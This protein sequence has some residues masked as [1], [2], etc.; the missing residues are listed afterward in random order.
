MKL[1]EVVLFP[2]AGGTEE[3]EGRLVD[4]QK[5]LS[6]WPAAKA[7][8]RPVPPVH[9]RAV[10]CHHIVLER[11][12]RSRQPRVARAQWRRG[13]AFEVRVPRGAPETRALKELRAKVCK[14]SAAYLLFRKQGVLTNRR[15]TEKYQMAKNKQVLLG[16]ELA[17][18][19]SE[20]F[21]GE[22]QGDSEY[23]ETGPDAAAPVQEPS[24]QQ[25][26]AIQKVHQNLGHPDAATLARTLRIGG[27]PDYVWQW[28]KKHFRCPA[29]ASGARPKAPRPAAVPRSY[30]PNTV[31][32]V[33]LFHLSSWDNSQQ[34][35]YLNMVDLGTNFQ[36][37]ERVPSKEPLAVWK[38]M[39]RTW[40][41]FLGFPQ[42]ILCD[43]GTEFLGAFRD[44]C[45]ELGVLIHTIGARAPYQNGRCERHGGLFKMMIERAKWIN[46]PASVE[47]WRLLIRETEAAKNRLSDRSGFSPAQRMLGQT[48]RV[49]S[50]LH[51]DSWL[52][53]VLS[54]NDEE[55]MKVLKARA[56]AQRA[57]AETN[58][59]TILRRSLRARPRTQVQFSPGDV[60][61]VWRQNAWQ[62]PGV[63]VLPEGANSYVNMKGK[64][65]KVSNEHVRSAV[66]EE[67]K[68]T[69]AVHEVFRDLR[70]R[71]ARDGREAPVVQDLT[72]EPRPPASERPWYD[73]VVAEGDARGLPR[74][75][76]EPDLPE[77]PVPLPEP[78]QVLPEVPLTPEPPE[79]P[80]PQVPLGPD[81]EEG[82][83]DTPERQ[84]TE[85]PE[86][87]QHN[88]ERPTREDLL[89]SA[90][91]SA[92]RAS[93]VDGL[94]RAAPTPT[95]GGV[96]TA[97][98]Q[99]SYRPVRPA[100]E[101]RREEAPHPYQRPAEDEVFV[102]EPDL[103]A[104][105]PRKEGLP[106]RDRWQLL[107]QQG[108]LRRH[109]T[110]WRT[111]LFSPWEGSKMP[112]DIAA[113]NSERCTVQVFKNGEKKDLFDDWRALR[114]GVSTKA[115]SKWKGYTDFYLTKVEAKKLLKNF[116]G[117][118]GN[119]TQDTYAFE[120]LPSEVFAAKK[121][122][123]DEVNERDIPEEEWP[124][125]RQ[126]DAEEWAKIEASGAVRV[127]SPQESARVLQE[128]AAKGQASRVI[129]SRFVRRRKPSE[130]IGEPASLKSRWCVRGD[131]DPDAAELNAY[132][133]TVT[134]QNLQV[135]LQLVASL[136][137]PGACG[138]LKAAFTQSD[139]LTRQAGKLYV[140]Q[141]RGGLPGMEPGQIMEVVVGV[142]G[143]VDG[144]L[145]W[146]K[147]LKSYLTSELGFKQSRIDPTVFMLYVDHQLN[148]LLVVEIDDILSFGFKEHEQRMAQLQSRFK[149]GKYKKLQELA[150]G[151][152]FNGRRLQQD[153]D[154]SI[155]VDMS[156]FIE[157]RLKP[158]AILRE[159]KSDPEAKATEKEISSARGAVGSLAWLSKEGRPDLAGA[160]SMLAA[161]ISTLQVK[162]LM[163]INKCIAGAKARRDLQLKF[164]PI[165]V[166]D[167]CWG[168]VTDASW[169]NHK[170]GSSQGATAVIAFH[171]D[172]LRGERA[173]CTMIWWKSGKLRRKVGSTLAAEAQALLRGLGDL[174]W[175]KAV[176]HEI[177]DEDFT[178]EAFKQD[179]KSKAELVLQSAEADETLKNSLAV[180]DAKSLYDNMMKDGSQSQDKFTALDVAIARERVDGLGVE[181]RWVEHQAMIVDSLTKL[182][183]NKDSMLK[184]LEDGTFRLEA[185][186][187]QLEDRERRRLE[188]TVKRR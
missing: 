51:S 72:T 12:H 87:E 70:D 3:V 58:C 34:E 86:V 143:L 185:E 82:R 90:V 127:L 114:P 94:P 134:T 76:T 170:D 77:P 18:Q 152:M 126:A 5:E 106:Q 129:D 59:S 80:V 55:L 132:A 188:G 165:P 147:T 30:S 103:G 138:D 61:Y 116:K 144:P 46:A 68:G 181:L 28:A 10:L 156:K 25:K 95:L 180:V 2:T 62:G 115:P 158:M 121:T 128:L 168:T 42:M 29:C 96:P 154:F 74:P 88:S 183:G 16:P 187:W 172:L 93:R 71:F 43:Q 141:P 155:R 136:N 109:H 56:A 131:M 119:E 122:G 102:E 186:E 167:L 35:L 1:G 142:Y 78:E 153:A 75:R 151:T 17:E 161:R 9:P 8:V 63:V 4:H 64:L 6:A 164:H 85:E 20:N 175:A 123:S 53:P 48:P 69:E 159:R 57:W 33:D 21:V 60:I 135:I 84:S 73:P 13:G 52:D 184:L 98:E 111:H 7:K 162:D 45:H 37:I 101:A 89:R 44:K 125:W 47:E 117:N 32:A 65:W 113:L 179:V 79:P 22:Q 67:I 177:L 24:E 49:G 104:A 163:D 50:E 92:N 27:A 105:P 26:A 108:V 171:R 110:K 133:P 130:Q 14:T 148:G 120:V 19:F 41:R 40:G 157:E 166:A 81:L 97:S 145:H 140:R 107:P 31:V 137:M 146:R 174:M 124:E 36:M 160:A 112:L 38:A 91:E 39:A 23:P 66:S 118:A 11:R 178:L 15:D 176:Y 83:R 169:A 182:N 54:T 149:F 173:Q 100:T 99:S 150:E 139:K